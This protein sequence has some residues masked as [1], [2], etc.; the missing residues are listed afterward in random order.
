[1][2]RRYGTRVHAP[3]CVDLIPLSSATSKNAKFELI[4][5]TIALRTMHKRMGPS[6]KTILGGSWFYGVC[7][8]H[9]SRAFLRDLANRGGT[10]VLAGSRGPRDTCGPRICR[11]IERRTL[12]IGR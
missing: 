10:H 2:Q 12:H 4:A 8:E 11:G 6:F 1:M 5:A 9:M 3:F 7:A